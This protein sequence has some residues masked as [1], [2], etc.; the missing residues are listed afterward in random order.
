MKKTALTILVASS[1]SVTAAPYVGLEYGF[2]ATNHNFET[3]FKNEGVNLNPKMKDGIFG[4][5][6]GYSINDTWALE[7]GYHQFELEDSQSQPQGIA[8][9]GGQNYHEKLEWDSSVKAKQMSLA[10]VFNY[11]LSEKWTAKA[12]AGL[13]Y[14]QYES[15]ASKSREYE[16]VFNDDIEMSK[17]LFHRSEKS[18]E[19][20]AMVAVGAEYEIFPQLTVG[21]NAKY[22]LDSYANTASI[23]VGSTYYF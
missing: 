1:F 3:S 12:K 5:F 7:L 17:N 11:A 15:K 23:N 9:I 20:G 16:H 18:N 14:T 2:G 22:Q 6:V 13:T 8:N 4:G 10:P 21:A 19:F